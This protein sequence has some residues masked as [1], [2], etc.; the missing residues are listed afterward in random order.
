MM[1]SSLLCSCHEKATV[2][3]YVGRMESRLDIAFA[4]EFSD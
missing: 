1:I 3:R 4:F 2:A